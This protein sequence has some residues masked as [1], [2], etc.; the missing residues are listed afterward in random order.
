MKNVFVAN[1][2]LVC[3]ILPTEVAEGQGEINE[4]VEAIKNQLVGRHILANV[5]KFFKQLMLP[6]VISLII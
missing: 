2:L 5:L 4:Q 3:L 6:N 1:K